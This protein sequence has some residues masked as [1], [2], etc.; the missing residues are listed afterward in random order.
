MKFGSSEFKP[1]PYKF[2]CLRSG[3]KEM[4][5]NTLVISTHGF[6]KK[7]EKVGKKEIDKAISDRKQYFENQ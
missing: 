3:I 7:T 2:D 4:Q 6:I 1:D 5:K